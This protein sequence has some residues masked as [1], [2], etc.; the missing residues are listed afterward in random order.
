MTSRRNCRRRCGHFPGLPDVPRDGGLRKRVL[1][2]IRKGYAAEYALKETILEY[3]KVFSRIEDPYLRERGHDIEIVGKRILENLLGFNEEIRTFKKK[4]ILVA[5]NIS[6]AELI[7]FR[8]ENLKGIILTKGGETSHVTILARS[9]EIPMVIGVPGIQNEVR[10][11]GFIIV[12]GTSGYVFPN[13]T[14]L[15][16]REY[17]RMESEKVRRN[18]RLDGLRTLPAMTMDGF[19]VRMGA[20]IG[21][22]SDLDLVEKYGADHSACTGRNSLSCPAPASPPKTSRPTCTGGFSR[23]PGDVR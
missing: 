7:R 11:D 19:H 4:T 10:E 9:F 3:T 13:P 15:V 14:R 23:A 8:Q 20:N 1:D 21:L 18:E 22:L 2:T 17:Q 12:D 16:V 6:P 5:A